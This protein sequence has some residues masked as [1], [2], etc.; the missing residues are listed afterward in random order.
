MLLLLASLVASVPSVS[1]LARPGNVGRLPALGWNSWNAYHCGINEA[2]FL[3]A[4]QK[5]IDYGLKVIFSGRQLAHT[6]NNFIGCRL[7]IC[8]Y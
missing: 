7:R 8:E 3:S 2:K 4:A 5:M 1:G 6:I